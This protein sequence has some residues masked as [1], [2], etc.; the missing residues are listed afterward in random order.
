MQL[1]LKF[2]MMKTQTVGIDRQNEDVAE[3]GYANDT[4][5][6]RLSGGCDFHY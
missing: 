6:Y 4:K 3:W 5:P 2:L 1:T